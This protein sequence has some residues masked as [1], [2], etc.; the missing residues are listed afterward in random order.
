MRADNYHNKI[1]QAASECSGNAIAASPSRRFL[2]FA[3]ERPIFV[4]RAIR[5]GNN[6]SQCDAAL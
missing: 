6:L 2:L 1:T 4:R 5:N 3:A